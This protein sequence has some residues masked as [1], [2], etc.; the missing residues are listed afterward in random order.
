MRLVSPVEIEPPTSVNRY[1]LPQERSVITVRMHP[2]ALAGPLI[3]AGGG[4]LAARKLTNRS[5]RPDVVWGAYLLVSLY[6]LYRVAAWPV[7]YLAVTSER[8]V[9]IRGLISRT[10]AAMPLDKVTGLTLRRTVLGRLL[11]HGTL[12]ADCPGR[13]QAFRKL[14]YVPYPEQLY[15]EI[16]G[17]LWREEMDETALPAYGGEGMTAYDS[18]EPFQ[19]E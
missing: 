6:S 9:L 14:R 2:A 13:R 1:L 16:S 7:T 3:L 19:Q 5:A 15:L 12:I 11:G 4:L 18:A 10:A 8:M 17:L